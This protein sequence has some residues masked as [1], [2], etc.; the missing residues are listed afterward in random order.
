[1]NNTSYTLDDIR[2][3]FEKRHGAQE[4][5]PKGRRIRGMDYS[6]MYTHKTTE[7]LWWGYVDAFKDLG[8]L[9]S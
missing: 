1:M 4:R 3:L 6:G 9:K 8:L 5:Y 2:N 7:L